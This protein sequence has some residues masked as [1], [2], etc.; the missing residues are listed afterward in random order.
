M[1]PIRLFVLVSFDRLGPMHGHRLRLEAERE[2]VHEWTDVSVGAVYGV[3]KRLETEGL[4]RDTG[5]EREGNR[6]TRRIYEITEAGRAALADLQSEGLSEIWF[7]YDP[8]DVALARP[9]PETLGALPGVIADRL[10]RATERLAER[11]KVEAASRPYVGLAE[12]WA[13]KHTQYRLEAEVAYLMDLLQ[14]VGDIVADERSPRSRL[15]MPY[16]TAESRSGAG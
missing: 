16:P 3:M 13:L 4:L 12:E 14:V 9:D 8:F 11:R 10:D 1:S 2:H 5:T 6:P 15:D 7:R